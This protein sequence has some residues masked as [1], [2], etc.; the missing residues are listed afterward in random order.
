LAAQTTPAR[1]ASRPQLREL[2]RRSADG[3]DVAL[4]WQPGDGSL[5]VSVAD[6]RSGQTWRLT[7]EAADALAAYEH[8]FAA[9]R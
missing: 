1:I 8:P 3:L 2:A 5:I 9:L 4:Y 7:P 6:A